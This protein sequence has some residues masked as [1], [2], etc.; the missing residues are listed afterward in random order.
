VLDEK[1]PERD[2]IDPV[3][4]PTLSIILGIGPMLPIAG[5]GLASFVVPWLAHSLMVAAV[6]T[7][8]SAILLF[9]AGVRRG[10]GFARQ[11]T[12][13]L[14]S[15]AGTIWIFLTGLLALP[16]LLINPGLSILILMAGYVSSAIIDWLSARRGEAPRHFER[17]RPLQMALGA[18]GLLALFIAG[19]G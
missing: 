12:P 9:I 10:Y 15:L 3:S 16:A 7:W 11:A 14:G 5:A 13:S 8:S 2:K 4:V 6:I 19:A 1:Q 17:F 18:V